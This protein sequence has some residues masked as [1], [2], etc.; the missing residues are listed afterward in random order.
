ME[1]RTENGTHIPISGLNDSL[2]ITVAINN[3]SS[4]AELGPEGAGVRGVPVGGTA[5][6]SQCDYVIVRVSAGNTNRQAGLFVQ[7]NFTALEGERW[8]RTQS[9]VDVCVCMCVSCNVFPL[10]CWRS[11]I[12]SLQL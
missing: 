5:N 8:S 3:S 12:V 1:F 4:G 2:A 7:L 10:Y 11:V 6:I 9:S